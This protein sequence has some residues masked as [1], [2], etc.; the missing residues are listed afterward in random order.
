MFLDHVPPG[1]S[2]V[3]ALV[4]QVLGMLW[5]GE[6][7]SGRRAGRW[8]R[9]GSWGAMTHG[10]VLWQ[11]VGVG[12]RGWASNWSDAGRWSGG[13]A[14]T[15]CRVFGQAIWIPVGRSLGSNWRRSRCRDRGLA[16][17]HRCVLRQA[18]GVTCW[19]WLGRS[20]SGSRFRDRRLAVAH[21]RMLGQAVWI[22]CRGGLCSDWSRCG[23]ANRSRSRSRSRRGRGGCK[24]AMAHCRVL[25]QAC[26]LGRRGWL[27]R[28]AMAAVLSK[29]GSGY[30]GE[31]S[32]KEILHAASPS[33]GR[34]FT[35]RI[36]PACM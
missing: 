20:W 32:C 34:T 19:R 10:R 26:G 24:L 13:F 30:A 9:C 31:K 8:E 2:C 33:M 18:V 22:T 29:S 5:S 6:R 36:I 7:R 28:R 23:S 15:H 16:V 17:A 25:R 1:P 21:C 4:E 35:T 27:S 12:G 14:M 3:G 11:A